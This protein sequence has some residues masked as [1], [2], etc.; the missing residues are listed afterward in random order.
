MSGLNI[1]FLWHMH[2]PYYRDSYTGQASMPWVRMHACKAYTDMPAMLERHDVRAVINLVPSLLMQVQEYAFGAGDLFLDVA[3]KPVSDLTPDERIF[4]LDNF[5]AANFDT[6]IRPHSRYRWLLDKRRQGGWPVWGEAPRRLS[7]RLFTRPR[8]RRCWS[9]T[10]VTSWRPGRP[11]K[12]W[13]A[14]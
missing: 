4:L 10:T 13:R 5:F 8:R 12:S 1:A 11:W 7:S 6:M 2:Q 9:W 14:L 3:R